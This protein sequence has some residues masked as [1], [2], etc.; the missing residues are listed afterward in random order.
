MGWWGNA[1]NWW[2]DRSQQQWGSQSQPSQLQALQGIL[3]RGH[4]VDQLQDWE[5]QK[6]VQDIDRYQKDMVKAVKAGNGE[7]EPEQPTKKQKQDDAETP[8]QDATTENKENLKGKEEE[9]AAT[10]AKQA[11][12][13]RRK[14]LHARNMRFYRSLSSYFDALVSRNHDLCNVCNVAYNLSCICS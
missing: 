3:Q 6:I 1:Y 4:T 14:R 8:K 5:L 7:G 9:D 12:E 2:G 10:K 11:K 13:E